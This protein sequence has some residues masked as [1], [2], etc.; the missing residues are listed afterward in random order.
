MMMPLKTR[1]A[2]LSLVVSVVLVGVKFYAWALTDSQVVL[3]DALESIINV[4]AS[5]F[6]LYSIYLAGLPKDDNHPYGHGKI[7]YLSVGFEGGLILMA[8]GY[9]FYAAVLALWEPHTVAQPDWGI[10][11]LAATAVV[12]LG[13][14][15]LLVRAGRQHH[16]PALV[17]DGQHLYLD[18]VST[19]VSCAALGL[20]MLTGNV[21]YD[22]LA[23]LVLGAFI[24]LNG[25]RMVRR[26]VSGLMDEADVT[27]VQQVV[28]ELQEHREP[29]WIDVHNLRV[30][31]YGASLHIDCHVTMP[32]Y[33]SLEQT[34]EHVHGIEE[35]VAQ[36]FGIPVE[37]F[38]HADPCTFSACWHCHVA[39]CPV[40]RHPFTQEITW[41]LANVAKNERH[42]L[43]V[44]SP[45]NP[46]SEKDRGD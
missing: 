6:A 22:A 11:L 7:E 23:S 4:V 36:E 33:L 2:L 12:N 32:Y 31:R 35:L 17:G 1:Y 42:R 15:F 29:A 8:G 39:D 43:E 9:I 21:L 10:K 27:T 19:F 34:H 25:F 38:V 46:L 24:V 45:P 40:R 30:Q 14:G 13:T 26:S 41:T 28:A 37:M 16:S 20:V 44:N 18:A 5:G 3:T